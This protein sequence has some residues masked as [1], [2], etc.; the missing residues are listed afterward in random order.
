MTYSADHGG[1]VATSDTSG[2]GWD[3]YAGDLVIPTPSVE[4]SDTCSKVFDA[5]IE[6]DGWPGMAVIDAAGTVQGLISR[7]DCLG[8]LAKPLMLDL[9]GRRP[10]TLIMNEH[11]LVV[12]AADSIDRLGE[13]IVSESPGALVDG[14]VITDRG[15]YLGLGI[16]NRLLEMTVRQAHRRSETMEEARQAADAA[17]VAKSRFLANMSHE[18][19]TPLNAIIGYSEMLEEEFA[20]IGQESM[21][22][23][24]RKIHAA[25][26]H[27][28]ALINDILDLSKIEAGKTEL[29]IERFDVRQMIDDVSST[30]D[31][32]IAN[33]A[34]RLVVDIADDLGG[35]EADL[36]KIRQT[37]FNLLSNAAKFTEAGTITLAARRES[38]ETGEWMVF[39]VA[40]TG[41]GMTPEQMDKMF[42][43]FSQADASTTRRYG[44]TGLGL[45]ISR[46]FCD[47]M[48]GTIT[49]DSVYGH[50]STFTMRLPAV[51]AI[52]HV[53][54]PPAPAA[55]PA[56]HPMVLVIDDDAAARDLLTRFLV[57][58]DF[59][60]R[61]AASGEQGLAM[62]RT[63]LPAAIILDVLMPG[64]D[65]WQVLARLRADPEIAHIPVIMVSM[66]GNE[67]LGY[68]LGAAHFL[69]KPV[70]R[71]HLAD[72]LNHFRTAEAANHVLV[73]ED[74]E[75]NRG[76][77]CRLIE[78]EGW[79][80]AEA[81]HGRMG[82][83]RMAARLP[84]LILLDLM[85]PEMDGF[86]F[87]AELR[88]HPEWQ[89]IPV[90]VLTAKD[91][92]QDDLRRLEG[93]VR[94]IMQK[95]AVDHRVLLTELHR[96]LA[97]APR[98]KL[99]A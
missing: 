32:L 92:T 41:I 51:V 2:E 52:A 11:P 97:Q 94:R 6:N 24:L 36:T 95:G 55:E 50:G 48:G 90:V 43:P 91:I 28:L 59:E 62:A 79:S 84:D 8:I 60:P 39:S 68:A 80:V 42:Q 75:T 54:A 3:A 71:T 67:A 7:N 61:T 25:G 96:T 63:L 18:L 30:V 74:D 5:L 20:D 66:A 82:L 15:R 83:D 70:D 93:S 57:A 16:A 31:P 88:R 17:N 33:K 46:A 22:P 65:G 49:L 40:D 47:M 64:T 77:L 73:V 98:R 81:A 29:F 72:I 26:R 4:L 27:L 58:N 69:P 99:L 34:N 85:M 12:D 78:K 1:T 87:T 37:L 19:R 38:A 56:V 53:E 14:F 13:R 23:D 86:Q 35:M 9:Y 10:V 44:G 21:V 76:M 45:A 89:N